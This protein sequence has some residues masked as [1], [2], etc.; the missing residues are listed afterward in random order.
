MLDR[1]KFRHRFLLLPVLASIGF[2][3]ILLATWRSGARSEE[4]LDRI[5]SGYAPAVETSRDL[6][7]QLA[8]IQREMDEAVAIKD[9]RALEAVEQHRQSFLSRLDESRRNPV[10]VRSR[11]DEIAGAFSRYYDAERSFS[12]RLISAG[13]AAEEA[14]IAPDRSSSTARYEE[15]QTL[16]ATSTRR[17]EEAFAR[18]FSSV[19]TNHRD[20]MWM[21]S[22]VTLLCL[23]SLVLLSTWLGRR[24]RAPIVRLSAA[25][26][27][28]AS[29]HM[30]LLAIETKRV[31]DGDLTRHF[32]LDLEHLPVESDDEVGQMAA[33]FN[34]MLDKL[35]E[36]SEA[37]VSMSSGL[38]EI[39]LHLQ[40]AADEVATGSETVVN[41]SSI[42]ARGNDSA[43]EAVESISATLHE[44]NANTQNVA[45][46]AQSQ[47]SSSVE[48]LASIKALLASVEKVEEISARLV[49]IAKGSYAAVQEGEEA[50][51]SAS[52]AIDQMRDVN[53]TSA[54]LVEE[55]GTMARG[56][57]KIVDVIDEIAEQINL[58]AL[59]AAIEAARAGEHGRGFAVVADEVRKLAE[60]SS[61]S[62]EEIS[63]L[64]SGI[65]KQVEKAVANM[66]ASI[67]S[68]E[69]GMARTDELRANLDRV[70]FSVAEVFSWSKDIGK[71]TAAQSEGAGEIE[72]AT[73]RLSDLTDAI[74]ASTEEQSHG[75]D[76][77]VD[78]IERIRL[79]VQENAS[80]VG[81]LVASAEELSRQASQLR[82]L[83]S[84]FQVQ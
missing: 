40:R 21:V 43:V 51:G 62:T 22:T 3:L 10:V 65:Q 20:S 81:S 61:S 14:A 64:V 37:I 60:R 26:S 70:G 31:A 6:E 48:T 55:L 67:R 82:R 59:N 15:L 34:L 7:R 45:R 71:A 1:L 29:E 38:R 36:I 18:A 42:A 41:A 79:Q 49:E 4:L 50:M 9:G 52:E 54:G 28:I 32:T 58:L 66:G 53:Q 39:V 47:A 76:Q 73:S 75:T 68:V 16:L 13:G 11:A 57:G 74:R 69:Q 80:G 8:E 17:D 83:A 27:R 78:A 24:I 30:T 77:I 5:Q 19:R 2:L 33:A 25:A 46:S 12:E 35:S 72:T 23:L 56:I 44:L 84:R 63:K